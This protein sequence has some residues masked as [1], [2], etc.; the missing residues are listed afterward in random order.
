[1]DMGMDV[2]DTD[3]VG[4][5]SDPQGRRIDYVRVSVTDRCNYR[6]TYCLPD[7]GI[8]HVDR[9]DILS[10]EEIVAIV[11]CFAALGVRRLRITG[12]EPTVRRDLVGLVRRLAAVPGIE[13][14]ALSTNGHLLSDLAAPLR[15]AGVSRLNVSVDTLDADKFTR[16]SRRGDLA[17]VLAGIDAARAAGF[18]VIKTNTVAIK[19]FNDGE[20]AALCA[21]AWSRGVVPRFIEQMPM[22]GGEMFVPGELLSAQ[23]IRDLVQAA[24]PGAA[25]VAEDGGAARG[26]GPA[27]YWR[28]EGADRGDGEG[29]GKT[30]AA[31]GTQRR[32]GIISAMTEH[33]CDTCNR[34]RVS[35][36][37][38]LHACLGYDD[39]VDLRAVLRSDGEAAVIA[40]IRRAVSGKRPAHSFGLLGIGGPRKSMISI[41]G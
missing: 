28:L 17:R 2:T 19:G 16:I 41:G 30:S 27:R 21:Y 29:R 39:A 31:A 6:C 3:R 9:Q 18:A 26:A 15:A 33:F 32:F 25:L 34:V 37:G 13:D 14:L 38:A 11:G 23:E 5:L 8:D 10:F 35:A 1:M 24:A 7:G 12:G 20:V 4:A 22:A 40:A 36:S